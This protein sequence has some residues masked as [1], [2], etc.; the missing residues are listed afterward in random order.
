MTFGLPYYEK[1]ERREHLIETVRAV[2]SLFAGRA[3]SGGERVPP[4][5][6]PLAAAADPSRR[7][8]RAGSAASPTPSCA[9][10]RPRSDAW[11]GWAMS[12]PE[13]AAKADLL[14]R[15]SMEA[16]REVEATWAGIVVAG[17]DE[18]DAGAM[19]NER[20][21][22]GMLETNVWAGSAASLA[23]WF[24]GL[25]TAGASWAIMVA[26]GGL[27]RVELIAEQSFPNLR[28]RA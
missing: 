10:P 25:E 15:V 7:P 23:W 5:A 8:A 18:D 3:W 13:F 9:S 19:L 17:R 14:R 26:A 4:I 6:G 22:K 1:A 16:G 28:S 20:Y 24:E 27:E 12:I 2:R 11:N 21:R